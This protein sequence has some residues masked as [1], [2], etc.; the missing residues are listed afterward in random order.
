VIDLGIIG[1]TGFYEFF[2]KTKEVTVS[3]E[4]GGK[5]I[6]FPPHRVPYTANV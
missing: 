1:G 5:T 4:F 3:T 6:G 2:G